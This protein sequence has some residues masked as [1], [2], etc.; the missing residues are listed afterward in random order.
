MW[1]QAI[2]WRAIQRWRRVGH[3]IELGGKISLDFIQPKIYGLTLLSKGLTWI[4]KYL[5]M[6][7]P[8]GRMDSVAIGG[9]AGLW[10]IWLP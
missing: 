9:K 3:I 4:V 8:D 7:H 1:V 10:L 2:Y 5:I 6:I